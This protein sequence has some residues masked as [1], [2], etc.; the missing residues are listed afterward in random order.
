M[1]PLPGPGEGS[2]LVAEE[3]AFQ[4]GIRDGSAVDGNKRFP[5]PGAGGVDGVGKKLLAGSAFPADENGGGAGGHLFCQG[6]GGE[7]GGALT[8]DAVK[9]VLG[10]VPLPQQLAANLLLP[11]FLVLEAL[12]DAK[13]P[14]QRPVAE[15]RLEADVHRQSPPAGR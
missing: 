9:G 1:S 3:L 10:D 14:N 15:H 7:D 11:L 2:V 8:H 12:E 6:L 4:E 5:A 13:G